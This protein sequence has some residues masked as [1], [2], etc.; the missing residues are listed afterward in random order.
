MEEISE[1]QIIKMM[2]G[3]NLDEKYPKRQSK[4]GDILFEVKELTSNKYKNVSFQVRRGELLGLFGLVGAGRTEVARGIFG[5]DQFISGT[6]NIEGKQ[7]N[8]NNP[9]QAIQNGIVL[10]TENR[11]EEGLVL[12]HD[13]NE[14]VT[15]P[16]L[17]QFRTAYRLLD[18]KSRMQKTIELTSYLNLKPQLP[19]R[20][21]INFSGGNQQ[22][23]VI[24][25]WLLSKAKLFIF[26]EPTKGVDVGAKVEIYN[27]MNSLLDQG[28]SILMI[29]SEMQEILGMADRVI[30][31]YEG[32]ITGEFSNDMS[33]SQEKIMIAATGGML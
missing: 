30:V 33:I 2:V 20:N 24:A 1:E 19:K 17:E 12:M 16:A 3:R 18:Q 21:A 13:V 11:K 8:I 25:K 14:N 22:K 10:A 7:L 32:K 9:K 15:M 23:I 4:I 6:V 26:D 27:I 31:M 29:S 28:V 5:A